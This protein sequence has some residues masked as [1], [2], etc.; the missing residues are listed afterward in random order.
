MRKLRAILL[1]ACCAAVVVWL[2]G[3]GEAPAPK[4]V[5]APPGPTD[6]GPAIGL[7]APPSNAVVFDLKYR[8]QTGE[9]GDISY[10]AY[11]GYGGSSEKA[12]SNAFLQD[13]RRKASHLYYVQN[14]MF[15]GREWSAVEH[16]GRQASAFYFDLNANGKFEDN[17][18]IP[19]TRKTD[20][21]F[22]FILPDFMQSVGEGQS[23]CRVLLQVNFYSRGSEPN[24]MWGPAAVL[25]GTAT[26]NDQPGRLLLY[27]DRPGGAFDQY[28]SSDYSLL[29][30]DAGKISP[31]QYV[32]REML[33]TLICSEGEFYRLT[34]EGRRSNGLPARV[35]LVKDTSPTGTLAV[36][37]AGSNVLQAGLTSLYLQGADDHNVHFRCDCSKD[38]LTLPVG[39]YAIV[40]G[41]ASYGSSIARDWEVSFTGGPAAAIKAEEVCA[42]GL[43]QPTLKVRAIEERERY[44]SNPT[45][46]ASFKQGTPI[47]LEPKI[48]GKGGEV[49]GRFRQATARSGNDKSDRPP[50]ITI[51]RA[52]GKQL[53]SKVMEYG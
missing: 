14:P 16:R 21:G 50:R 36:K 26:I 25:E 7:S 19:P 39:T 43:G 31:G 51:T 44:Q 8:A 41:E 10:H 24:C 35:L 46:S 11:W 9:P 30:G 32:P 37:L 13:V 17:E 48:V 6:L 2:A 40:R 4:C 1:S 47:Y 45:E 22:E 42:V 38:K 33:S 20:Q 23:L 12:E 3:C 49:F 15:K 27:V 53:L 28:G 5:L 18:R 52:D 29:L 34:V